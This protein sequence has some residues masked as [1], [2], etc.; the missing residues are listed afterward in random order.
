MHILLIEP[1][2]VLASSYQ[3]ALENAEYQVSHAPSAQAAIYAADAQ[4]PDVVVLELQMAVHNG[5]AFLHE[6]RSYPE[7]Q[8]IPVVLHTYAHPQ[9]H[10][11]IRDQL[12]QQLGVHAWLYKPQTTLPELIGIV[13]KHAPKA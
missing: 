4:R 11:E 6:F 2:L 12:A 5:I 3:R 1:D 8:E 10:A 13:Q 9:R 7:W